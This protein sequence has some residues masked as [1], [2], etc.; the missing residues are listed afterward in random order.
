MRG[1]IKVTRRISRALRAEAH[2]AFMTTPK[3]KA[4]RYSAFQLSNL[5]LD[6]ADEVSKA[7]NRTLDELEAENARLSVGELAFKGCKDHPNGE[8]DSCAKI[9]IASTDEVLNHLQLWEVITKL[10]AELASLRQQLE[11]ANKRADDLEASNARITEQWKVAGAWN[12]YEGVGGIGAMLE[13]WN[14]KE[15]LIQVPST[16]Y[17][18][19]ALESIASKTAN[20]IPTHWAYDQ[21]CAALTKH[22]SEI[23]GLH[24]QLEQARA[25]SER[26]DW[27]ENNALSAPSATS[28]IRISTDGIERGDENPI[29]CCFN[30]QPHIIYSTSIRTAIDRAISGQK[31]AE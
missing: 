11:Q 17:N 3:E 20:R 15:L 24:R 6:E 22:K 13:L 29:R 19:E 12:T 28:L 5:D 14:G 10:D 2:P 1:T 27:L 9:R 31:G 16:E 8:N 30:N 18:R 23:A 25:D 4:Q 21:V 26:L 7:I